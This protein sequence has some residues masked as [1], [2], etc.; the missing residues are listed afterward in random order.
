[1]SENGNNKTGL[2]PRRE[3]FR[4]WDI[5]DLKHVFNIQVEIICGSYCICISYHVEV[6]TYKKFKI[7]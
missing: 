6:A 2:T 3:D 7:A 5:G 4:V 1:M